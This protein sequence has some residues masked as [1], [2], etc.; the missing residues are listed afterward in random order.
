MREAALTRFAS[1]IR[2]TLSVSS[3]N[4]P[5]SS[6]ANVLCTRSGIM[7]KSVINPPSAVHWK[8]GPCVA[9]WPDSA[10]P[11]HLHHMGSPSMYMHCI[12]V[13][14]PLTLD[15]AVLSSEARK[16]SARGRL[17]WSRPP[18]QNTRQSYQ[19]TYTSLMSSTRCSMLAY[20]LLTG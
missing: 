14:F 3:N 7:S 4:K 6:P 18:P 20:L 1:A 9:L 12:C 2:S 11:L 19:I 5:R 16:A 8:R 17:P 15:A 10:S 13:I